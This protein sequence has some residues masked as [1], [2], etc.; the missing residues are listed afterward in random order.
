MLQFKHTD[1]N[2]ITQKWHL[3]RMRNAPCY[4]FE[5]QFIFCL[6]I[7]CKIFHV[8]A[9]FVSFEFWILQPNL[10]RT[11]SSKSF[12]IF[13]GEKNK[14]GRLVFL[15]P[16]ICSASDRIFTSIE[17]QK[18]WI[19]PHER[20]LSRYYSFQVSS[21][22]E[23]FFFRVFWFS[24]NRKSEIPQNL[25]KTK[26]VLIFDKYIWMPSFWCIFLFSNSSWLWSYT[27]KGTKKI[28]G[29]NKNEPFFTSKYQET[30]V[31]YNPVQI[32][33][34]EDG[35]WKSFVLGFLWAIPRTIFVSP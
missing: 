35:T 16:S 1:N 28:D 17:F 33:V 30:L 22:S 8:P 3:Q 29:F 18:K 4:N 25:N 11:I 6:L 27:H 10:N 5:C 15:N 31:W 26:M 23:L 21:N 24:R 12:L 34:N 32:G 19:S 2:E 9:S 20:A 7:A 14:I 13:W